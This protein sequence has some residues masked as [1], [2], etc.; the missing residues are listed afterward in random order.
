MGL[1][2]RNGSVVSA[3]KTLAADVLIEGA[4]IKEV[5]AG[6]PADLG[7]EVLDATGMLLLPDGLWGAGRRLVCWVAR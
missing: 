6:I 5:R 3:D 2:I 4:T 1:L 7:H